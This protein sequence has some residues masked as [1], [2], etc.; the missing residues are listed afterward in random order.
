MMTPTNTILLGD[1]QE[2]L[3]ELGTASVD[4]VLTS[5]PFF[6]LRDYSVDGQIG[7]EPTVDDWV[8]QLRQVFAEVARVLVPTG[9]LWIDVGDTYSRHGRYGAPP[10]A[11]LLAPERLALALATD[12][13]IIR[14]RVIWWK[15]N[16]MPSSVSDRLSNTYDVVYHLVRQGSY[17]YDL[18][19]IREPH[20][21]DQVHRDTS[22]GAQKPRWGGPHAGSNAGLKRFRPPGIPG[23]LLGKNPGDVL[24]LPAANFRG[25]HHATFPERLVERPLLATCPLKV[26]THCSAP[27]RPG[28]GKT[29]ILGTRK[30][31]GRVPDQHV[32]RYT[33]TWRTYHQ[34][35]ELQAG[36]DCGVPTRPGL[37]LDP[38]FGSGTTGVV[39]E[40][41]HRDWLGIEL[42]E[43]YVDLAWTRLRGRA[44]T[45]RA[46]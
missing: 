29:F 26:C 6:Q 31:A 10:K 3:G 35:G 14:N 45:E 27:W 5:V 4:V 22:Q 8:E 7:L 18:D 12:G 34:A 41:L 33:G 23:H 36:C 43:R 44:P 15:S 16:P 13:W 38:F 32:R 37:V 30:P 9:S 39:A 17:F 42:S 40:R 25:A 2:R 11:M 21:T 1:A 28:P 24:R 46:A 19:A 20:R